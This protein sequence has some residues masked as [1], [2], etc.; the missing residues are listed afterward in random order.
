MIRPVAKGQPAQSEQMT[1]I[2]PQLL[3]RAGAVRLT[4]EL[5]V[6]VAPQQAT[7][8]QRDVVQI[9]IGHLLFAQRRH[10]H[11]AHKHLDAEVALQKQRVPQ[12]KEETVGVIAAGRVDGED[13]Q[14]SRR[15][16][17]TRG[18]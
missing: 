1:N 8:T 6:V 7:A 10:G 14:V 17:I 11:R 9:E 13:Q 18:R 4:L 12:G 2:L 15:L 5:G 16:G 3:Q